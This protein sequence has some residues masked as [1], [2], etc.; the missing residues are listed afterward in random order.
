MN[1]VVWYQYDSTVTVNQTIHSVH[2]C[3]ISN[4]STLAYKVY[5]VL[6]C[7]VAYKVLEESGNTCRYV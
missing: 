3:D 6:C 1:L 5:W 4:C 7:C 2:V